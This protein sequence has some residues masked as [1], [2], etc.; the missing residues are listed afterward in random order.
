MKWLIPFGIVV[1][2][3][4]SGCSTTTT[5]KSADMVSLATNPEDYFNQTMT[6][7][8]YPATYLDNIYLGYGIRN[9]LNLQDIS[10]KPHQLP[11]KWNDTFYCSY[12]E[13]RGS[14][15]K[16]QTCDCETEHCSG[17]VDYCKTTTR[18]MEWSVMGRTTLDAC[19][20]MYT[21]YVWGNVYGSPGF[22]ELTQSRCKDGATSDFYYFNID[23]VRK[24]D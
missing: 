24:I 12:C 4:V 10:G 20:A 11:L 21:E 18:R 23:G 7:T 3:V 22:L 9:A 8:G 13:F 1:V 5:K 6:I 17:A 19:K 16:V 14:I 2:I 15:Q